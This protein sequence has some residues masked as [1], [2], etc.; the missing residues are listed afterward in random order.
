MSARYN[1]AEVGR[2]EGRDGVH[3]HI[4]PKQRGGSPQRI[5]HRHKPEDDKQPKH[6]EHQTAVCARGT[7]PHKDR[8]PDEPDHDVEHVMGGVDRKLTEQVAVCGVTVR[9]RRRVR[10]GCVRRPDT[11]PRAPMT[12]YT[13]PRP[14]EKRRVCMNEFL[15]CGYGAGASRGTFS[16]I[17]TKR[18]DRG[19]RTDISRL[20]FR[21]TPWAGE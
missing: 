15:H 8:D 18:T 10:R 20:Q 6:E 2:G 9:Q 16:M 4:R 1:E 12:T 19:T 21:R 5:R 17:D 14:S 11:N 3:P 7:E 13:T